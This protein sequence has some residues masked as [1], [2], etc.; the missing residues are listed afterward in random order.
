MIGN[1][2]EWTLDGAGPVPASGRGD[3]TPQNTPQF[4][5]GLAEFKLRGG[6]MMD[7]EG[8]H[9]VF[10][11]ARTRDGGDQPTNYDYGFRCAWPAE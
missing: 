9:V 10:D 1:V 5:D 7:A 6:S 2:A 8:A 11:Q 4:W 3:D